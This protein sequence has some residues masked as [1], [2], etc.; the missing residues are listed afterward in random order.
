MSSPAY[1]NNSILDW[2]YVD[3][4]WD[5]LIECESLRLG[6]PGATYSNQHR[7]LAHPVERN[8][9]NINYM[10]SAGTYWSQKESASLLKC[11]DT[12]APSCPTRRKLHSRFLS[13]FPDLTVESIRTR[14]CALSWQRNSVPTVNPA[15]VSQTNVTSGTE[16]QAAENSEWFACLIRT[17]FTQLESDKEASSQ[18]DRL[19]TI[20]RGLQAGIFTMVQDKSLLNMHAA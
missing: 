19:L 20:A 5:L 16:S 1:N 17:V 4:P 8:C 2:P 10:K 6:L 7:R 14:L 18:T 15:T 12:L 13:L 3:S 9:E 11:A